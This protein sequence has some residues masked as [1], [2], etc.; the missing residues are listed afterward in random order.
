MKTLL[1]FRKNILLIFFLF[2]I[3]L[4]NGQDKQADKD[5]SFIQVEKQELARHSSEPVLVEIID[6]PYVN[7]TTV[8]F[9]MEQSGNVEVSLYDQSGRKI[10]DIFSGLLNAGNHSVKISSNGMAS[11]MY[12]CKVV[13]ND[14]T[15]TL[16][17]V[18]L[19]QSKEN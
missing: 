1:W 9:E 14:R 4:V 12:I 16:S 19:V 17:I 18:K 3:V 5:K 15:E 10:A 2:S 7:Y 13:M 11:G 6:D 8:S